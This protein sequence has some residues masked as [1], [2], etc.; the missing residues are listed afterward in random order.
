VMGNSYNNI[1][2]IISKLKAG[3]ILYVIF[4]DT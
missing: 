4:I 3:N 2:L 1:Q